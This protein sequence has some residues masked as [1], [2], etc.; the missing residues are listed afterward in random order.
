VDEIRE[1]VM[2]RIQAGLDPK[3]AVEKTMRTFSKHFSARKVAQTRP[4]PK[5]LSPAQQRA[6]QA[7]GTGGK[8]GTPS[9][10]RMTLQQLESTVKNPAAL[11][12]G[13]LDS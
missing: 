7:V 2:E 6:V 8:T 5:E 1:L 13:K 3:A 12:L 4:Q 10:L 11:L 9:T